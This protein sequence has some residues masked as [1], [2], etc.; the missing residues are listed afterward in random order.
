MTPIDLIEKINELKEKKNAVILAHNY[1]LPEIQD[2]ADFTGDSLGLSIQAS[3]TKAD[4]IVFCGVYFMAETAKIL[5]PHKTVIIPEKDA[6]CPM[7]DMITADQL[8][9]LKMRHPWAKVV[10]YVNTP[11]AVK[12]ESDVCCT[13]A[14]AISVLKDMFTDEDEIIFVPDKYLGT[15]ASAQ[16]NR[17]VIPWHGY[18]P[19]HARILPEHIEQLKALHPEAKVL[20]HPE[21]NGLVVASADAV[22]STSGMLRYV[23][24]SDA[25][26]FI[27]A[28]E[29]GMVYPL[30][31]EHPDKEFYA[32]TELAICRNMKMVTLEKLLRSLEDMD[33]QVELPESIIHKA[34]K[35]INNM[36]RYKEQSV[37]ASAVTP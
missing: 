3:K 9:S 28:T 20:A 4:V 19:S 37:A 14:N 35:S 36:I 1:Q 34:Q 32:A 5:S 17:N 33:H 18:C 13:S 23:R 7:A 8:R 11:A 10:C 29:P 15:Y 22:V 21:C 24:E 12:A 6:G 31:K 27:I 16:A 30:Q 2:I 25:R 26:E